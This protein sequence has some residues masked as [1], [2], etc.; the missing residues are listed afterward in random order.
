MAERVVWNF[1]GLANA[2]DES[3]T[4]P[5]KCYS[6]SNADVGLGI[7]RG[8]PRY[9]ALGSGQSGTVRGLGYGKFG[10][11][12]EYIAVVDTAGYS[13]NPSTGAFTALTTATG[14]TGSDWFFVQYQDKIYALN[15]TDGIAYKTIGTDNWQGTLTGPTS[16]PTYSFV[17]SSFAVSM[18]SA[19]GTGFPGAPTY[20]IVSSNSVVQIVT[21]TA[22]T[23]PTE[24]TV[25]ATLTAAAD[26]SYRDWLR[27]EWFITTAGDAV[28]DPSTIKVEAINNDGTPITIEPDYY[29][30][31]YDYNG[32]GT[33]Y[34]LDVNFADETRTSRDN[35]LKFKWTFT[36]M[37]CG[38]TKTFWIRPWLGDV[39]LNDTTSTLALDEGPVMDE[40][41][42]AYSWYDDSAGIESEISPVTLSNSIPGSV[43]GGYVTVTGTVASGGAW[44]AGDYVRFYRKEKSTG[45]WRRLGQAA[46]SGTPAVNDK[47]MEHE[48]A[49]LTAYPG[50]NLPA[51]FNG[52]AIGVW[53]QCLVV[54]E[55]KSAS[56]RVGVAYISYVG[57]PNM[58]LPPPDDAEDDPPNEDDIDRGR[59]VYVSDNRAEPIYGIH[60]QDSLYFVTPLSCY[61]MVGD[62]PADATPPRRLPGSRGAVGQRASFGYGGGILVGSEDGLWFYSVGRGFDGTDNGSMVERELTSAVRTSWK[63][64]LGTSYSGLIV[65]EFNDEILAINGTKYLKLTREGEWVE[66]TFTDSMTAMMPVRPNG[67]RGVYTTGGTTQFAR[68]NSNSSGTEY[69]TDNGTAVT[70]S[71]TTGVIDAPKNRVIAFEL[72]GDGQPEVQFTIYP[73]PDNPDTEYKTYPKMKRQGSRRTWHAPVVIMPGHRMKFALFGTTG[74]DTVESFALLLE[75]SD[76]GRGG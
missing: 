72:Q 28:I 52:S 16:G 75:K 41:E 26:Y 32:N 30:T 70:W 23:T 12:E 60:G 48:L 31:G 21:G 51:G 53:K 7:L 67:L 3:K 76:S 44:G 27:S 10:S 42:Y 49:A 33:H 24:C 62:L 37:S 45:T 47:Y 36:V 69:T 5:D 13:I 25:T 46:N 71:Y 1:G 2:L 9:A 4:P 66:G 20:S 56:N 59:S 15:A 54:G 19:T 43:V 57:Q 40:I 29:G 35:I 63:N 61:A 17:H 34:L 68:F 8:M 11:N 65:T 39:W 14:L 74:T 64:L 58:F 6:M 55:N 38:A 22:I 18:T 73:D 50:P